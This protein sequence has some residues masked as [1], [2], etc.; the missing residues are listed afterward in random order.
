[1]MDTCLECMAGDDIDLMLPRHPPPDSG[2]PDD[3]GRPSWLPHNAVPS[4][5]APCRCSPCSCLRLLCS[6]M[7]VVVFG[8]V[9]LSYGPYVLWLPWKVFAWKCFCVAVFHIL[10][11]LLLTSYVMCVFT[12]PGTVPWAWHRIIAADER[13]SNEHVLCRKSKLYRP[14]R[15]HFCSITRRVVLNMCVSH[16]SS[17]V[18]TLARILVQS[19]SRDH[20]RQHISRL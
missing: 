19:A 17:L 7:F 2:S 6:P 9:G 20:A 11:A 15:S 14:L 4:T 16:K 5:P 18:H 3:M 12:D 8:I 13:L 1:M 10:V